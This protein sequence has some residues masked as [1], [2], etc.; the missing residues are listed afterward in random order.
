M[1]QKIQ[2][3]INYQTQALILKQDIA[4]AHYL[5]KKKYVY[6]IKKGVENQITWF[7]AQWIVKDYLYQALVDF[8][9]TFAVVVKPLTF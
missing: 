3:L 1:Q 5:L 7:K 6:K 9:Q 8:D 2:S 4:S